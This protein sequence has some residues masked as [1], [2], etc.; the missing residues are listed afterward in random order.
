MKAGGKRFIK[1]GSKT[2][3]IKVWNLADIHIGNRS[4]ARGKFEEDLATI[5]DDPF[6]FWFGGG[7]YAD[8]ISVSDK[9]FHPDSVDENVKVKD[10]GMLGKRLL[11]EFKDYV[12]PIRH[13]CLGLLMGNH[14]KQYMG[15]KEQ[16]D[17]HGWLCTELEVPNLTYSCLTDIT[18]EKVPRT[19]VPVLWK[20][21]GADDGLTRATFR[22][23]L[24]HGAGF[25]NTPG[26]KLNRLI[27]FMQAFDADIFMVGHVHDQIAKRIPSVGADRNCTKLVQ[28]EKIG[29]VTGSYLKTYAED[30]TSYGEQRGY[31]PVPLG[32]RWVAIKPYTREVRAEI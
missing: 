8:C 19:R 20:G 17:L 18:F 6:S 14:E 22:F 3:I 2:N 29:I 12:M 16:E 28:K 31:D 25:A 30:T 15:M 26:G 13:K 1:Y 27:K 21:L 11:T 32:A 10:L 5:K 9:R 7:D 23:F 4:I 24:H